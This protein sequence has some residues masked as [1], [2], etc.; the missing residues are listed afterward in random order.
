MN[1]IMSSLQIVKLSYLFHV[2]ESLYCVHKSEWNT[3]DRWISNPIRGLTF[4]GKRGE[5]SDE[6]LLEW[7]QTY[8]LDFL[9]MTI[10]NHAESSI[11]WNKIKSAKWNLSAI[12]HW[13]MENPVDS[14]M[15]SG[16]L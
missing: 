4:S 2:N 5:T 12:K 9:E 10:K 8:W 6:N 1:A 16:S 14:K 3:P 11:K 13:L 15:V 7:M